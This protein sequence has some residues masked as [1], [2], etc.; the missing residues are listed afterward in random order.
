MLKIDITKW[1][2]I[3]K[4]L[5]Y[6]F[7]KTKILHISDLHNKLFGNNQAFL[8]DIIKKIKPSFIFITGDLIDEKSLDIRNTL[9]LLEGI[10]TLA[11]VYYV[12]GNHEWLR[13]NRSRE[14]F[15][16][17]EKK[18]IN[19]LHDKALTIYR[20]NSSIQIMGID[21]PYKW[22]ACG[23]YNKKTY[24]KRYIETLNQMQKQKRGKF[25]ILLAHRP[26]FIRHYSK[27]GIDLVFAGHAHGGM[28]RIPHIGG[29]IAPHQGLL[30][31][32]TEGIIK[33]RN[34]SLIIS[35]GL[36]DS[37]IPLRINNNPELVVVYLE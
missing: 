6:E 4:N 14:L 15:L 33:N 16:Y 9:E 26:E 20:G 35:R 22:V 37:G 19:V 10:I 18:G 23:E 7:K 13:R 24:I 17:M 3:C 36:G 21:D 29:L 31:R 27:N 5:P 8:I 32:Y 34:T 12:T 25:T 2:C 30:P 11:P 28:I 1:T